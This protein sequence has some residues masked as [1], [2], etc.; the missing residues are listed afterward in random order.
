MN[1]PY[2]EGFQNGMEWERNRIIKLLSENFID[3]ELLQLAIT[4]IK[5]KQND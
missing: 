1:T 5:G 3:N 4:L 2:T